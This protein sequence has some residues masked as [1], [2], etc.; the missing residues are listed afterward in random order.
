[1]SEYVAVIC[2]N[3]GNCEVYTK[4]NY[5]KKLYLY[6][7]SCGNGRTQDSVIDFIKAMKRDFEYI[8]LDR[9]LK[10]GLFD[11]YGEKI[12]KSVDK[13]FEVIKLKSDIE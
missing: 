3:C 11:Y 1:M 10:E 9:F 7:N 12:G 13:G 2:K 8:G 6:C 4:E 5:L